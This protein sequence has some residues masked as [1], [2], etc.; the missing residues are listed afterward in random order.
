[1]AVLCTIASE[2][3]FLNIL[4]LHF[5]INFSA[6]ISLKQYNGNYEKCNH[7]YICCDVDDCSPY[8]SFL[9]SRS[10]K[11]R[12]KTCNDKAWTATNQ[13]GV[14]NLLAR[15]IQHGDIAAS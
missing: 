12:I 5:V 6:S 8:R 9:G 11:R 13:Y 1:M 7:Q 14:D 3:P 10:K 4:S 2:M 15:D